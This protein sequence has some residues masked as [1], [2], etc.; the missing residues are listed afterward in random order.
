[1]TTSAPSENPSHNEFAPTYL[2][3]VTVDLLA[4][5]LMNPAVELSDAETLAIFA[6]K[7]ALLAIDPPQ[8]H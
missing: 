5:L 3:A 7:C 1:M 6:R 2:Q 4:S 8:E